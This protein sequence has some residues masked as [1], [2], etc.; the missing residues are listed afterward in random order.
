MNM[1]PLLSGVG[2]ARIRQEGSMSHYKT[3]GVEE[4][5]TAEQIKAAYRRAARDCHPDLHPND[6]SKEERFKK[7]AAAYEELS[8]P[9]RKRQYDQSLA[10]G[11]RQAQARQQ[12]AHAARQRSGTMSATPGSMRA[13]SQIRQSPQPLVRVRE[14]SQSLSWGKLVL[15]GAVAVSAVLVLTALF[16]EDDSPP[17]RSAHSSSGRRRVAGRAR[18]P[19]KK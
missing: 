11:R 16:G 12:N 17:R 4:S 13:A 1:P 3:L 6:T 18:R 15:G 8:D 9:E 19:S 7:I 14:S 10:E 5:A 2:V